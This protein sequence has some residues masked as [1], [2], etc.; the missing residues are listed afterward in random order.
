MPSPWRLRRR[1]SYLVLVDLPTSYC[2]TTRRGSTMSESSD[3]T[4][5]RLKVHKG[6]D[7]QPLYWTSWRD[8]RVILL[9]EVTS[10]T[11]RTL[12]HS[13]SLAL[14]KIHLRSEQIGSHSLL[15][16]TQPEDTKVEPSDWW[17]VSDVVSPC[18]GKA[19]M[20]TL[21]PILDFRNVPDPTLDRV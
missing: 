6:F 21:D 10:V 20:C 4:K 8:R 1:A 11:G 5:Q 19:H 18:I 3:Q 7:E 14:T 2:P 17:Q 9:Q 13:M 15:Q 12:R 16:Y